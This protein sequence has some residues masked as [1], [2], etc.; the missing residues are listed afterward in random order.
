MTP[1][2]RLRRLQ[3][4]MT[5][6]P[7]DSRPHTA[8]G[9][10]LEGD[11]ARYPS[12]VH[13]GQI[14]FFACT[15]AAAF[16]SKRP[17]NGDSMIENRVKQ[18]YRR[19]LPVYDLVTQAFAGVRTRAIAKLELSPGDVV[20]D[21]G[22]GT[23]LSFPLLEQSVGPSGQII[24]VDVSPDMLGKARARLAAHHWTN[25]T[26]IEASASAV[27]LEPVSVDNVLSFYTNDIMTTEPA[28]ARAIAA[29]RPTGRFVA[30]GVKLVPNAGWL[31]FITLAY[32]RTGVTL[33]ITPTPWRVLEKLSGGVE[34]DEYLQ[35]SAY[36]AMAIKT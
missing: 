8:C 33:P 15:L 9:G 14:V 3:P 18:L 7:T 4:R 32:S 6:P 24:G 21:F 5:T 13:R 23:G 26:L 30:A 11:P 22:C 17:T 10:L 16:S 1:Q 2:P 19:N 36:V 34:V 25:I 20:L 31:N 29:L 12:A 28:V 35:G 27:D